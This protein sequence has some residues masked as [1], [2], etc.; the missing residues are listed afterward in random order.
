[1]ELEP[2]SR[3]H[4]SKKFDQELE[5][6]RNLVLKMGGLVEV[7]VRDGQK[8]LLNADEQLAEK[9]FKRE[10]NVNVMEIEIDEICTNIL[11]IRQPAASDLRLII[12]VIK[13]IN[14]L[15]RIGDEAEKLAQSAKIVIK[16]KL[17][18]R[19]Y[20]ELKSLG[21]MATSMLK[22]TLDAL[23]RMDV[24]EAVEAIR[25]DD[26]VNIEFD[27]LSRLLQ[28][29]M[30]EDP[31]VIKDALTVNYSARALERIGDHAKNICEHIIF[32]IKGKDVRHMSLSELE[33]NIQ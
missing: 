15:E 29:K 25:T 24:E 22:H 4:I 23:A 30:T 17:S 18:E 32:L 1:M 20:S 14:D 28:A 3:Q 11:A 16:S 2:L 27:N 8:A 9:V 33:Q 12:S 5:D 6:L 31:S 10:R 19:E 7:Q 21:Q 13:T 26:Q